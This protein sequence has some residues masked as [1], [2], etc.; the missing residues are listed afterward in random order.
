MGASIV[1]Y[2]ASLLIY[3]EVASTAFANIGWKFYLVFLSLLVC[4]IV[5]LFF[6]FPETKGLSLEEIARLFNDETTSVR[7]DA[8][9]TEEDNLKMVEEKEVLT[10]TERLAGRP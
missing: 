1:A 10:Q 2:W 5:P 3:L 8:P 6:Y 9:E 4:F 7:L